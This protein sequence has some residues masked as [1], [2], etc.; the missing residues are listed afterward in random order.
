[1][2]GIGK[3]GDK[4]GSKEEKE[5]HHCELYIIKEFVRYREGSREPRSISRK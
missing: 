4:G 2:G 1:M 3:A 5:A